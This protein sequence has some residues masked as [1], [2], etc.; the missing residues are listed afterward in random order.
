MKSKQANSIKD[1]STNSKQ[2]NL[3]EAFAGI[4]SQHMALKNISNSM[5]WNIN[6]VGI[7]EW[8]IDAIIAYEAIHNPPPKSEKIGKTRE[9]FKGNVNLSAD[10][11]KP[12]SIQSQKKYF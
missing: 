11:K 8:F 6:V 1:I 5:N 3:F 7:V 12:L 2:I 4:G 9:T 10:S